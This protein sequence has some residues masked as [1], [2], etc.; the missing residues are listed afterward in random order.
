MVALLRDVISCGGGR[1]V[2]LL[3]RTALDAWYG[4]DK[5]ARLQHHAFLP[6]VRVRE[7]DFTIEAPWAQQSRVEGIGTIG[8]HD[9]FHVHTGGGDGR[10]A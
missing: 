8:R 10:G 6:A 2:A 1:M 7:L 5:P 9:Y 4:P 3:M